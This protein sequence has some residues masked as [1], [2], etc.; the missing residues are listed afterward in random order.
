MRDDL[1][2]LLHKGVFVSGEELAKNLG[3]SRTAVWKQIAV[4]RELGYNIESVK[5]RGYRLVSRPD[6]PIAV[7]VLEELK[8]KVVGRDIVYFK[9]LASTNVYARKLIKKGMTARV[10]TKNE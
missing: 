2:R 3:V 1:I 6:I 9:K 7:E 8:C 5:N 10:M 4:L